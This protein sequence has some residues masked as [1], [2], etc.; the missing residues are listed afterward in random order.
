VTARASVSPARGAFARLLAFGTLALVDLVLGGIASQEPGAAP[1]LTLAAVAVDCA[2]L[3]RLAGADGRALVRGL[4]PRSLPGLGALV[5]TIAL[6]G[7]VVRLPAVLHDLRHSLDGPSY[8]LAQADLAPLAAWGSAPAL[9]AAKRVIPPGA[10]Y[11]VV[12]GTNFKVPYLF[13][14]WL[15]PRVFSWNVSGS[16]WLIDYQAP[17]PH[18]LAVRR[19]VTLAPDIYAIELGR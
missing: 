13:E 12:A 2:L 18:G 3:L 17:L 10:T 8:S 14:M 7:A 11:T 9:A 6:A 15:M 16:S 1:A 5:V 19:R 4:D